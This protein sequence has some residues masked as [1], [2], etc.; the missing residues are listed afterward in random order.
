MDLSDSMKISVCM[1]VKN[2][3]D[4]LKTCLE[5]LKT[6]WD[7]LI[8][9]DTGSM[10][11]T[12]E[13]ASHYTDKIY[14]FNWT[15]SFSDARNY[16]FSLAKG[17]YIYSADADEELDAENIE[18]FLSLKNNLLEE[19]EIVEMYYCNQLDNNT[20]YNYDREL[21]PKLYKRV[22]EYTWIESIHE[23][24]R[25][26]P[27][28]YES[29]I[30]IIHRP[31]SNHA[32]RDLEAFEKLLTSGANLSQRLIDIYS[33]ELYIAGTKDNYIKAKEFFEKR[34]EEDS[35]DN[36]TRD[37]ALAALCARRTGDDTAMFKYA[38]RG[39]AE[40]P[41]SELCY[42]LGCYFKE[43]GDLCEGNMWFYNAVYETEPIICTE[44]VK[45][46]KEE[47]EQ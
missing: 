47:I 22:R 17:D 36:L 19:I 41:S 24:V 12:K 3:E 43:K 33:K 2:E 16:A 31:K 20:I 10:D 9:V 7:E 23:M 32:N 40:N 26:D 37:F 6:I 30:E 42:E 28:V 18:R 21:R 29:D 15:G 46:A 14:D 8:I 34:C 11:S 44:C 4:S 45:L 5:S 1:I 25:L 35:G 38:L 39:I 13:I 27:V